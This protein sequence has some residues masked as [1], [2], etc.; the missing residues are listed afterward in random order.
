MKKRIVTVLLLAVALSICACAKTE[1]PPTNAPTGVQTTTEAQEKRLTA[2]EAAD[3]FN[4]KFDWLSEKCEYDADIVSTTNSPQTETSAENTLTLKWSEKCKYINGKVHYLSY[5]GD[6][7]L[8][9]C[10]WGNI[11]FQ[12]EP[13]SGKIVTKAVQKF[14]DAVKDGLNTIGRKIDNY[15]TF[16]IK[17]TD[18]SI[19]YV[20]EINDGT[21]SYVPWYINCNH[22]A[23]LVFDLYGNLTYYEETKTMVR[24]EEYIKGEPYA[25]EN[26]FTKI[27][28]VTF[29]AVENVQIDFSQYEEELN[30]FVPAD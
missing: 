28:Q 20:F 30:S 8:I 16:E 11:Y 2:K 24:E 23:K 10:F 26:Y 19:E 14:T 3:L 5:A 7:M 21:D 13:K 1:Q 17:E 22:T 4:E 18:D 27:N 12:T 29:N 15:K 9:E 6:P 25:P